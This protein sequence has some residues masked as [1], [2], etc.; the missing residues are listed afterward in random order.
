M[1]KIQD[2]LV[3]FHAAYCDY[4]TI[5]AINVTMGSALLL[6]WVLKCFSG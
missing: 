2:G 6:A 5:R 1:G 3:A 4:R